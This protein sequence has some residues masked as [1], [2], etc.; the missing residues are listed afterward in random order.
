[1]VT[2]VDD[3]ESFRLLERQLAGGATG[4]CVSSHTLRRLVSSGLPSGKLCYV[5]PA[6]DGTFAPR[7]VTVGIAT[8]TYPMDGRKR[9][10]WLRR[11]AH[12]IDP[13]EFRF[14]IMGR[15]WESIVYKYREM[16]RSIDYY[17]YLS[18]DEGSMGFLD[19]LAAGVPTIA[20]PQGFHLDAVGGLTHPFSTFVDLVRVFDDIARPR[21]ELARAV[22]GWTWKNYATKHLD[23]WKCILSGVRV[24]ALEV[25]D[26]VNSLALQVNEIGAYDRATFRWELLRG[27]MLHASLRMKTALGHSWDRVRRQL[28][29]LS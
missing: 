5:L 14:V 24:A 12:R 21:R 19:A 28:A 13:T 6:H 26:G 25:P 1:M 15:G 29:R 27:S 17:L 8:R 16:M 20:T 22:E 2:H 7:P 11:V 9:E 23:I 10:S 4:I 18:T 3:V